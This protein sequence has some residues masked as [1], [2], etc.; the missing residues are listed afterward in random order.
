LRHSSV[1]YM[2]TISMYESTLRALV[3]LSCL[4]S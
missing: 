4:R 2:L 3:G 1:K